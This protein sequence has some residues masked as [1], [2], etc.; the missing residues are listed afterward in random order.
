MQPRLPLLI[1]FIL[2]IAQGLFAQTQVTGTV[3]SGGITRN[4][5]AYLPPG[6]S[7]GTPAPLVINMH[8]YGS[9][10]LQQEFYSGMNA[11]ADTAGFIVCYPD[12]IANAWNVGFTGAYHSGIDDVAF[13]R[14]LID[15]LYFQY[16][17][18]LSRVYACGMSN[19]G[20][21][22]YRL[23]CELNDRI[24]AIA[25]VTGA[26][27]DSIAFYC[28]PPRPIP[29][30]QIHGT[31]DGTVPYLGVPGIHWSIPNSIAY[32]VNFDNCTTPILDTFPDI[33]TT[34]NC[35][36]TQ[37][38]WPVCDPNSEVLLLTVLDGGHTW[39]GGQAIP[40][41]G[42]TNLDINGSREIWEFFLKFSHPNPATSLVSPTVFP[43]MP[44]VFPNPSQG[45]LTL[46]WQGHHAECILYR[47]DGQK[48]FS[49][50]M[51]DELILE[52][53]P[54]GVYFAK[55]TDAKQ[56]AFLRVVV[57]E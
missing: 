37:Q 52:E 43:D 33:N 38:Y 30:M 56:T 42:N 46:R 25:S 55:I 20:F 39:P 16:Q 31:T 9:N 28:N 48:W 7:P 14:A 18:D 3:L 23:A 4:Y 49:S 51:N 13:I 8:G 19:G 53:I 24:A 47:I 27:T 35:T 11:V 54:A 1:L 2:L 6:F 57:A 21:M 17:I 5:R 36:V 22:S 32:W 26:M 44:T 50:E 15:D 29:V 40:P 10:G 12:G 45:R 34:D 41:F